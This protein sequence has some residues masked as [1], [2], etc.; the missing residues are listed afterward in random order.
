M[1]CRGEENKFSPMVQIKTADFMLT[2][3]TTENISGQ[4]LVVL[5]F[6]FLTM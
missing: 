1:V 5:L 3:M 2:K 6:F 4:I